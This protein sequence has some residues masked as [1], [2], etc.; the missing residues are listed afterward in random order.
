MVLDVTF[1]MTMTNDLEDGLERNP[2]SYL[3]RDLELDLVR[4]VRSEVTYKETTTRSEV[5]VSRRFREMP[6]S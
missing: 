5:L 1:D 2:E 4:N 3:G 6:F